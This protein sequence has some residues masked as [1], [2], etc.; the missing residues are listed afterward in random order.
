MSKTRIAFIGAGNMAASLIGGL[1]AKGLE[2]AQIRA[3]DPGEETRARVSAEHG[4][5]V[6]ADNADAIQG[7]DVIVLAVKPQAMKA[8]CEAIRPSLKPEQLVVSIAA[9]ITCASMNNWL[10][11]QPIVRCMPNTPAL[12]RQG[13]SGL[14]AT[15]QVTAEQ[16]QQAQEL[17]SAVGVALWLDAEQQLDAVTAVSGSGPAYFFL[18]IEAMTAAGVKLGLPAD[19]AAQLTLQ[20][21]LGAAH[22]AVSSDV[23]AAEL[24]RRVTS[25]AG[26]TEAAI[27]SFQANGFEALVEKALGAAAHRSAEMAEQLGR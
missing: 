17:L 25:P 3:S 22:M 14:F 10:G 20:T 26:T 5:E 19:I 11:A 2:A 13:V 12:L 4:I 21:A 16:R 18:L 27:K 6:F 24:R 9:G 8:V 7:A 15:A 1:R 23:D